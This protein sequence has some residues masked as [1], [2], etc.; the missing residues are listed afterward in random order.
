M[1]RFST[2][3]QT[4]NATHETLVFQ[5][6]ISQRTSLLTPRDVEP[7]VAHSQQYINPF[8]AYWS[9]KVICMLISHNRRDANIY[10]KSK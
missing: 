4:F 7:F 1:R 10:K 9:K 8:H 6:F 2:P 3:T 5:P